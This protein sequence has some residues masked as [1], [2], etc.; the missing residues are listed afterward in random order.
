MNIQFLHPGARQP[1]YGSDQAAGFDIYA[2]EDAIVWNGESTLVRTGLAMQATAGTAI[3]IY[4]RSGMAT[5]HGIRPANAVGVV[6]ADY[7]GEVLVSL[8]CDRETDSG[9]IIKAGDRIAQGVVTKVERIVFNTVEQ[10]SAT[11]RGTG[12][13]GSSGK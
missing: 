7:R 13:F 5:K 12:G 11:A 8:T 2:A 6:D 9:F 3:F 10:L 4:A 1:T